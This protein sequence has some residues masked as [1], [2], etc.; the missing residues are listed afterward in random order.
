VILNNGNWGCEV[1]LQAGSGQV[2][3]TSG[4]GC[5]GWWRSQS[6]VRAGAGAKSNY[7]EKIDKGKA[8]PDDGWF[9]MRLPYLDALANPLP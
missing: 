7:G 1:E 2:H 8:Q 3:H 9:A 5:A 4:R 6:V